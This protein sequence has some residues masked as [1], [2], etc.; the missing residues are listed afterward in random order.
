MIKA[1]IHVECHHF[2]QDQS[3]PDI[4]LGK[5]NF[6]MRKKQKYFLYMRTGT[7]LR[8]SADDNDNNAANDLWSVGNPSKVNYC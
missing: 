7:N 1:S 8:Q 6:F 3:P 2:N 4:P 5:S